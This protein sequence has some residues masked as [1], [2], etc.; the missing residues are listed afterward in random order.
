[1]RWRSL[2]RDG[3][4]DDMPRCDAECILVAGLIR[5]PLPS[6]WR[7]PVAGALS[8]DVRCLSSTASLALVVASRRCGFHVQ[9]IVPK[10]QVQSRNS[11]DCSCVWVL[12]LAVLV[13]LLRGC[14]NSFA[15]ENGH[16]GALLSQHP[17]KVLTFHE[18]LRLDA[19]VLA[20]EG[21]P[22]VEAA[23]AVPLPP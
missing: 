15:R 5:G 17:L 12:L 19:G 9:P 4:A 13:L 7:R 1:V 16:G 20:V 23:L 6:R 22:G 2:C 21:Q 8:L 3:F 10:V 18:R 11:A 14:E